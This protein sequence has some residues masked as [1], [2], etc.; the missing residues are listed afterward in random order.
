MAEVASTPA[1]IV[2]PTPLGLRRSLSG[3][4]TR[5]LIAASL[6]AA[7]YMLRLVVG[8]S[9]GTGVSL[10]LVLPVAVVAVDHGTWAGI[11]AGL[12]AYGVFALWV[13]TDEMVDVDAYGHVISGSIYVL[14]GLATGSAAEQLRDSES[15]QRQ[16][17]DSLGDMVSVHDPEGRY[18]Y[19]SSAASE[20]LGYTPR[21]LIGTSAYDYFHPQDASA[22]RTAHDETLVAPDLQTAVYRVRRVDGRYLWFETVSRAIRQGGEVVEILCSSRDVTAR[23]TQRLAVEEDRDGLRRQIQQVLD[24]GEITIVIQPIVEL[25]TGRVTGYEALS[26]FPSVAS[27][28]PNVWFE[29][30]AQV[31]LGEALELMAISRAIDTF[32]LIPK[33]ASLSVNASPATLSSPQLLEMLRDAPADRLIVELTEH[34]A[35]TDYAQFNAAIRSLRELGVQL[36]VDDAGA[37]FASLRHILD[38]RPE[39]IKLD[40][41]LTRRIHNDSAR[42]ALASALCDFAA[43]LEADVV[44]EGIEE[45][46]ELDELLKLGIRYGQGYLLGKPSPA[47]VE[48]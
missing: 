5:T 24:D 25:A 4:A 47:P 19:V 15:R 39:I 43:N 12:A 23:E 13:L 3:A 1:P 21:E 42:R 27:R 34:A 22:V 38:L 32:D 11:L 8:P 16:I 37:G 31:G 18:L 35:I 40:M 36:A 17:A 46:A 20:L 2:R 41:S 14:V 26:R 45:Q 30:A 6:V 48:A 28:P 33:Q 9:P 44:A 29:H 7:I 10:L